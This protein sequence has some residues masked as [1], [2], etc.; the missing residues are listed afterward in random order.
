MTNKTILLEV[1]DPS[2]DRV[3]CDTTKGTKYPAV[4]IPAGTILNH[5]DQLV[6]IDSDA[7]LFVD[8]HNWT[9][10]YRIADG[11]VNVIELQ[12]ET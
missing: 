7:A 6:D 2:A 11:G 5:V 12:Q 4:L 9:I 8:D 3:L 10:L 1:T